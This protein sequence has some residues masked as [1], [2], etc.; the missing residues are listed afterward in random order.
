MYV[1]FHR[2]LNLWTHYEYSNNNS[3]LHCSLKINYIVIIYLQTC[4]P[5]VNVAV[6]IVLY[7]KPSNIVQCTQPLTDFMI[8]FSSHRFERFD[9]CEEMPGK[10]V[11][12]DI[13]IANIF[14]TQSINANTNHNFCK[15]KPSLCCNPS[16]NFRCN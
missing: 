13:N 5:P 15:N 1:H 4:E 7:A 3:C 2:G 16:L 8:S 12:D 14:Q 10:R 11:V 6:Q 9:L